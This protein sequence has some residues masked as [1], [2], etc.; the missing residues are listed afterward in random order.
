M[1]IRRLVQNRWF[2]DLLLF[3]AIFFA[4][5]WWQTRHL[6]PADGLASIPDI[7]LANTD[8]QITPLHSFRGQSTVYYFFAPWCTVCKA[9]SGELGELARDRSD[10]NV[11]AIGLDFANSA[12]I[13]A[14]AAEYQWSFP[15]LLGNSE[16]A[17]AFRIDAFPTYYFVDA[18]GRITNHSVGYTSPWGLRWRLP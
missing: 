4:I 10:L 15:T 3:V 17:A 13:R 18:E 2:R 12:E 6:L 11:V 7:S 8:D 14:Y 1:K 5:Q 9:T 16:T